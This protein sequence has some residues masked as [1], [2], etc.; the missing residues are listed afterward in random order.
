V[1]QFERTFLPIS[2]KAGIEISQVSRHITLLRRCIAPTDSAVVVARC[3]QVDHP[4]RGEHL[5][6][7]TQRQL[8]ITN[9]SPILHRLRLHLNTPLS[10]L[11]DVQW[12]LIP[13]LTAIE[14]AATVSDGVRERFLIKVMRPREVSRLE[15]S[16]V[17]LFRPWF[18]AIPP[19]QTPDAG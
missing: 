8:V 14:F 9:D 19:G 4:L 6:V 13:R 17:E 12:L 10:E 7:A 16:F 15:A 18:E 5:M 3:T 11:S 2:A 1:D